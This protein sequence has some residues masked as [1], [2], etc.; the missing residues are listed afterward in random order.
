[1]SS[2]VFDI[3]GY[4]KKVDLV[5]ARAPTLTKA[6]FI[7]L[8]ASSPQQPT[9]CSVYFHHAIV[10]D[11]KECITLEAQ[12][13]L[14]WAD[15]DLPGLLQGAETGHHGGM[16]GGLCVPRDRAETV[17]LYLRRTKR[18][19]PKFSSPKLQMPIEEFT[20]KTSSDPIMRILQE[21]KAEQRIMCTNV[22]SQLSKTLTKRDYEKIVNASHDRMCHLMS[23]EQINRLLKGSNV[24]AVPR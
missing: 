2:E 20:T 21:I 12:N 17:G 9:D 24:V 7:P 14:V 4:S 1:M 10:D 3:G 23:A 16:Y 13:I 19:Q 5:F 18:H 15:P 11:G 6:Q 22:L 8:A